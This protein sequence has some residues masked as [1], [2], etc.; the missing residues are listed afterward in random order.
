[1]AGFLAAHW[2][3]APTAPPKRRNRVR[4]RPAARTVAIKVAAAVT[5]LAAG[6]TAVA[7]ETGNLPTGAQQRAYEMFSSLGVPA[8]TG[9]P[10]PAGTGPVRPSASP[11]PSA[12]P[13]PAASAGDAAAL[14]LC[15][16][17]DAGR[18]DPHGKAMAAAARRDL[19]AAA[20]GQSKVA[21]FCTRLLDDP[22]AT[23]TPGPSA[24]HPGP[25]TATPSHPGK[26]KGKATTR[27][28]PDPQDPHG[29]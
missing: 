19:A 12:T 9:G 21:D 10:R 29:Q 1:M 5:V 17:W 7:A 16:A 4:V 2:N 26:G 13:A 23:S 3:A 14:G 8:P 6:G 20:G 18:K 24:T 22:A 11:Q 15:R 25:P 27:P 28:T